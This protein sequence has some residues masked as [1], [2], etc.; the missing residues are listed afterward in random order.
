LD[1]IE[2]I[3][4]DIEE[5][6]GRRIKIPVD[7][8]GAEVLLIHNAGEYVSWPENPAAFAILL[9]AAGIDWTLSSESM[10]SKA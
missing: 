8:K 7:K 5:R 4:D 10:G 6:I 2:F 1:T 3:E 9:D